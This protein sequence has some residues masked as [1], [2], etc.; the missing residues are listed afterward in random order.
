MHFFAFTDILAIF[1]AAGT[2]GYI[3]AKN[4]AG[5]LNKIYFLI[6]LFISFTAFSEFFFVTSPSSQLA[7]IWQKIS[8][9]WPFLPF[10]YLKFILILTGDKLNNNKKANFMLVAPAFFIVPIHLFTNL[11]YSGTIRTNYGWEFM[12]SK[13]LFSVAISIYFTVCQILAFVILIKYYSV[14]KNRAEKNQAL[15]IFAGL[16]VSFVSAVITQV[17]IP[18]SGYKIPPLNSISFVLGTTI[19]AI[20]ILKYRFKFEYDERKRFEN[21]LK[22]SEQKFR[23]L[24]ENSPIGIY[25]TT[26]SGKIVLANPAI[27]KMLGYRSFHELEE[28]NLE[29][30]GYQDHEYTRSEF[31][32]EIE[33][34][35]ELVGFESRWF[36]K[37]GKIIYLRENAKC[38]FDSEGNV[39]YYEGTVEDI[40]EKITAEIALKES[41][42]KFRSLAEQSPNVICIYQ[43]NRIVYINEKCTELTG[44]KKEH[45]TSETFNWQSILISKTNSDKEKPD[46]SESS[47]PKEFTLIHKNGSH[48]EVFITTNEI[49]YQGRKTKLVMV[50]DISERIKIEKALKENEENYRNLIE[51]INEVYYISD[52]AGKTTYISQNIY[53]FTGYPAGFF[54]GKS[55]FIL[56]FKKNLN[57]FIISIRRKLKTVLLMPQLNSER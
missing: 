35:G 18:E 3:L 29:M 4:S 16:L 33:K 20:G 9:L 51:N 11:L 36:R 34:K 8:F 54:I 44:Y 39:K 17:I 7:E 21:A 23:Q 13:N 57:G 47:N 45:F 22:E 24:F 48:V 49:L 28:R 2:G 31:K 38:V 12:P 6:N 42:E 37:D 26:P 27:I 15:W 5:G 1:I 19:I 41:E 52:R 56:I 43:D 14:Q 55:S 53:S 46:G 50:T 40:T 10:L 25:Q 32:S 30:E